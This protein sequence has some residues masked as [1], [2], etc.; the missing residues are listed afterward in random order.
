V[1]A[2]RLVDR[3]ARPAARRRTSGLVESAPPPPP[4]AVSTSTRD[5]SRPL[6][7]QRSDEARPLPRRAAKAE[8]SFEPSSA[9][10]SP[11]DDT[12]AMPE[13]AAS[14]A[15]GDRPDPPRPPRKSVE[16][17]EAA[18]PLATAPASS[19]GRPSH[20]RAGSVPEASVEAYAVP[21]VAPLIDEQPAVASLAER[22]AVAAATA[23]APQPPPQ[24]GT[25][26]LVSGNSGAPPA[27]HAPIPVPPAPPPVVIERI[28]VVTPAA[29]PLPVDPLASM[30]ER[31][32][33]RSRHG[34]AR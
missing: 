28:E 11:D 26:D 6:P 3:G 18:P 14:P 8:Q 9:P 29:P 27:K 33:G 7:V 17:A 13:I 20:A 4:A 15:H 22:G 32:A 12:A 16:E 34:A 1:S 10:P 19:A 2:N 23:T 24:P 21:P 25:R 30:A 31:R 5:E